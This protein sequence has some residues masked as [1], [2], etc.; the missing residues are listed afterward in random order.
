MRKGCLVTGVTGLIGRHV[1]IRLSKSWEVYYIARG[2]EK[3]NPGG[4]HRIQCD[5]AQD[6]TTGRFPKSIDA[7]IHLAQSKYFREFPDY[8]EHVFRVNVMSTLRLLEYAR[9]ANAKSFILASSGGVYGH[10]DNGFKEDQ[11]ISVKGDIGF[12]LGSKVCAEVL[13]ENYTP[14]MNIII[15]RFFF[16]YGSRQHTSML[17]PRLV[18]A[19]KEGEPIILHGRDGLK[20]NPTYVT[21]AASAV[22]QS[23]ELTDSHKINIAGP[24]VLSLR[25][26]G[27]QIGGILH[28]KPIFEINKNIRPQHLI[29]DIKKMTHFLG[30][31]VVRFR[32]G[33]AKYIEEQNEE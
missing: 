22:C 4:M 14:F 10:G 33:I 19:V 24:E 29:G 3:G 23:L 9:R 18:R 26:I 32:D 27:Q 8:S 2:Q 5:L 7:V 30:Q 21:D 25:Q 31:P 28:K 17:I 15:L 13:A 20:I 6:W 16:I 1:V 11:P 12:Y